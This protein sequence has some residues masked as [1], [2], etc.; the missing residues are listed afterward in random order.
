MGRAARGRIAL[1]RN[2]VLLALPEVPGQRANGAQSKRRTT[3]GS[4]VRSCA[5]EAANDHGR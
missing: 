4:L 5:D 1:R 3:T 2:P